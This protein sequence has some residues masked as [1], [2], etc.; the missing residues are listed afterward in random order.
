MP[1]R[2]IEAP[3]NHRMSVTDALLNEVPNLLGDAFLG[4]KQCA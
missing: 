3:A 1:P 2:L 4:G